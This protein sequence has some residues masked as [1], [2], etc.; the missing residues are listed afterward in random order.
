MVAD[1]YEDKTQLTDAT[2]LVI[3]PWRVNSW[4]ILDDYSDESQGHWRTFLP[5]ISP[6]LPMKTPKIP[7]QNCRPKV[8]A[9]FRRC[10]GGRPWTSCCTPHL[11]LPCLPCLTCLTCLPGTASLKWRICDLQGAG[12]IRMFSK[13]YLRSIFI[14]NILKEITINK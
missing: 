8:I 5:N 11:A 1:G 3:D 9:W 12:Q 10:T 2:K 14:S 6:K 7:N 13:M 4:W